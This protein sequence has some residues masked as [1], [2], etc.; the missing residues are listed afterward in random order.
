M[1][2]KKFYLINSLDS[3][4]YIRKP[5][6]SLLFFAPSHFGFYV[7]LLIDIDGFDVGLC[8]GRVSGLCALQTYWV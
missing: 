7:Y 2:K 5:V 6:A 3:F 1:I 8:I 4:T